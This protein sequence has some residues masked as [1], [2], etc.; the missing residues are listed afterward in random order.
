MVRLSVGG[1]A[2]GYLEDADG[3]ESYE[4]VHVQRLFHAAAHI[5][6]ELA[7]T[8]AF[9]VT[10]HGGWLFAGNI[11]TMGIGAGELGGFEVITETRILWDTMW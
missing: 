6:G 7:V 3:E 8:R 10:V 1:V 2:A 4:T 9:R 11:Q 5:G